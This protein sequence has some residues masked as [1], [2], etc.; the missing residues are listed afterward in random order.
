MEMQFQQMFPQEFRQNKLDFSAILKG[1]QSEEESYDSAI[2]LSE[3]L[4]FSNADNLSHGSAFS[5]HLPQYLDAFAHILSTSNNHELCVAVI[6]CL[7]NL[8]DALPVVAKLFRSG[9][10]MSAICQ[11]FSP[12]EFD[13]FE[14]LIN[15]MHKVSQ[16]RPEG[17]FEAG[18]LIAILSCDLNFFEKNLLTKVSI[19]FA[20]I[21]K[22]LPHNAFSVIL[23]VMD[24]ISELIHHADPIIQEKSLLGFYTISLFFVTHGKTKEFL[25]LLSD[26]LVQGIVDSLQD[27]SISITQE[28][29]SLKTLVYVCISPQYLKL[30]MKSNL[31][32]CLA[33]LLKKNSLD[34]LKNVIDLVGNMLPSI[35]KE[36]DIFQSPQSSKEKIELFI[37]EP[38]LLLN[39]ASSGL[40]S[41]LIDLYSRSNALV[42]SIL[43]C[44]TKIIYYSTNDIL[45][46]LLEKSTLFN[47]ISQLFTSNDKR[48]NAAG[49]NLVN[50]C[51]EKQPTYCKLFFIR[52]G[53]VEKLNKMAPI[54]NVEKIKDELPVKTVNLHHHPLIQK[55]ASD[56]EYKKGFICDQCNSSFTKGMRWNCDECKYDLC[57]ICLLAEEAT[58]PEEDISVKNRYPLR[59]RSSTL[60]LNSVVPTSKKRNVNTNNVNTKANDNS[61]PKPIDPLASL[62]PAM[63]KRKKEKKIILA[64]HE[65]LLKNSLEISRKYFSGIQYETLEYKKLTSIVKTLGSGSESAK[66]S[67][68]RDLFSILESISSYECAKS[69][70]PVALNSYFI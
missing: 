9:G 66:E 35:P 17:L 36:I 40:F 8:L 4:S 21:C 46:L 14:D 18:V 42:F 50:L 3:Y 5:Y 20:N 33:M 41:N 49:I 47:L 44:L 43:D 64:P 12:Q 7:N 32:N 13:L 45:L 16:E 38:N 28:N 53:V 15:I 70:I 57:D 68:L 2:Q 62:E 27:Y 52:N 23:P 54:L 10:L 30:L 61:T 63:K 26:D 24:K 56:S 55:P 58:E 39:I 34:T 60:T 67:A 11:K 51:M 69:G 22:H 25:M 1:L 29:S 65:I 48:I 31:C 6:Q 59:S 19:I 37:Q